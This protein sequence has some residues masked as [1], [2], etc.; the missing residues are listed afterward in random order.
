MKQETVPILSFERITEEI[1]ELTFTSEYLGAHAAPGQFI[2]IKVDDNFPLLRRP[3]SIFNVHGNAISI[4]FNVIGK[5]TKVLA[6]KNVGQTIDVIGPCGNSFLSF[7]EGEY[8]TAAFVAGGIGV[9]PFPFLTGR[10]QPGKRIVTYLG[11]RRKE[12]IVRKGLKNVLVA[13]EDGS[14][15]V[16]GTV[17]DR[18][19]SDPQR[20][21]YGKVRYFLCGPTRMMKAVA[22]YAASAGDE[23][24][25]S[26]ETDMACGIGLCQGCN[27]EMVGG[28]RKYKL[29]CK[30][31]TIFDARTVKFQ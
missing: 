8:D 3:F 23:C 28:E 16:K 6:S 24:F 9:A 2:N 18:I 25:A 27:V 13:T 4:V 22:D 31:G 12:M 10:I 26:L 14:E 30:E 20:S 15:G 17:L 1:L 21:S 11:A 5:G 19:I 29:V 7:T